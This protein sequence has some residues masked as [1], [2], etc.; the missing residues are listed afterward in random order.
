[1]NHF[2]RTI[3]HLLTVAEFSHGRT[4]SSMEVSRCSFPMG[5]LASVCVH[6]LYPPYPVQMAPEEE[7][8][9]FDSRKTLLDITG[10]GRC[11]YLHLT[12][13]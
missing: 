5:G 9:Y 3:A 12:I 4:P 13:Y 7:L 11:S 10:L 1:M 6:L 2:G 8:I